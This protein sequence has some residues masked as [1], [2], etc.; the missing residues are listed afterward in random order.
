M[1][2][3]STRQETHHID[4]LSKR[5]I[6]YTYLVAPRRVAVAP[7]EGQGKGGQRDVVVDVEGAGVLFIDVHLSCVGFGGSRVDAS[8]SHRYACAVRAI[9]LGRIDR[10]CTEKE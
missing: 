5:S 10:A 1:M 8:L 3:V 4:R 7:G 2:D 9:V 6:Q